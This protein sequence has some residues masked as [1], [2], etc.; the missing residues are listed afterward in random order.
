M[1][2]SAARLLAVY[3]DRSA[4]VIR[5]GV[6]PDEVSAAAATMASAMAPR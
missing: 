2:H 4:V 5:L 6:R 1:V 3:P